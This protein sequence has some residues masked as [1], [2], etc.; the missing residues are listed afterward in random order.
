[1]LIYGQY[2]L[3]LS[4]PHGSPFLLPLTLPLQLIFSI[5]SL[6]IIVFPFSFLSPWCLVLDWTCSKYYW[7]SWTLFYQDDKHQC[8]RKDSYFLY[9][10]ISFLIA[11]LIH[12]LIQ[13][14]LTHI[15]Q[16][17]LICLC[18]LLGRKVHFDMGASGKPPTLIQSAQLRYVIH[19]MLL[20]G[21][22]QVCLIPFS[23]LHTT[24]AR[25]QN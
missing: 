17:P 21:W 7:Q 10:C 15:C 6:I 1:M 19:V 16:R 18:F 22:P 3:P 2:E 11:C 5:F 13:I 14:C 25:F 9:L 12:S 4:L 24:L 8:L 23:S 20:P